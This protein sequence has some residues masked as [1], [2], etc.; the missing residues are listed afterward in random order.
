MTVHTEGSC[1]IDDKRGNC[2]STVPSPDVFSEQ[3]LNKI[4][5]TSSFQTLHQCAE[6][7]ASKPAAE[8]P[9]LQASASDKFWKAQYNTAGVK[10]HLCGSA[11]SADRVHESA[12]TDK[13][14]VPN[15]KKCSRPL[16][17][18]H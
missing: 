5:W 4:P 1:G 8:S 18:S 10:W 3:D 7:N 17:P 6:L 9:A 14:R 2:V 12:R 16:G 11:M 13:V 15:S